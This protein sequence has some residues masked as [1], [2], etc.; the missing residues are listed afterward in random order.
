MTF[1]ITL[2]W[3]VIVL[4]VTVFV[5]ELGHFIFAKRAGIYVHEFAIG[6]GPKIYKH[7]SKKDETTYS[8]GLFPIGGYVQMAGEE[9][10]EDIEIPKEKSL[11]AKTWLQRFSTII[12]G[13]TFN[14][15]FAIILLFIIGLVNG[16]PINK[17][18]IET[19]DQNYPI[20]ETNIA[21]GDQITKINGKKV[22]S[23]DR[24]MLEVQLN[25]GKDLTLELKNDH[26]T[27]TVT[28][29]PT[30]ETVDGSEVYKYGFSLDS[31]VKRGVLES[32]KYAFTK[33]YNLL[34]Q[35]VIVIGALCTGKLGLSSLSGPVGIFNVVG[36]SAQAGF[37]NII[38]L[39]AYI[40]INVGF[41]NL[42]PLPAF[43]G[44]RILFLII[45]KIK[46]KPVNQNV[47][48]IIHTVGFVC[49]MLLMVII[50]YNDILKIFK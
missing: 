24:F 14:F 29:S 44:G 35:L 18:Y 20:V 7:K 30:K 17:P 48:N 41:I 15:I 3:F 40:S 39:I 28:I 11:Q 43:D 27:K 38:Y 42:I 50:T 34:E 47:E 33:T 1:L 32:I 45:E 36:Q 31:S 49:L 46:G 13:I 22:N 12:A 6:M 21:V 9:I 23:S 26:E 25:Y 10:D 19:I 4:G 37:L 16:A 8:I 2:F 5:H